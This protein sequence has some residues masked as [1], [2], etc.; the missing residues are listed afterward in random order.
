M[1][2]GMFIL[3]AMV[4]LGGL[5]R[6]DAVFVPPDD[7][8][9]DLDHYYA[10]TWG[11]NLGSSTATTQIN[12]ATLTFTDIYN[13]R[14]EQDHLYIHLLDNASL[15][16]KRKWDGSGGGDYFTNQGILVI[17]WSDLEEWNKTKDL[18]ITFTDAQLAVLNDFGKDGRIAFG[19]D[20]DCHYYNQGVSF[21]I[22]TYVPTTAAVPAPGAITLGTVGLMFVGWLRT[23][24]A[25]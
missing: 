25:L 15:G 1:K 14:V 9:F 19:L 17:D 6:A 21:S 10:Y 7:D 3:T 13:W 8:I 16:L 23:R 12:S 4:I 22:S 11:I 24:K 2:K 20:P 5:L 18:V